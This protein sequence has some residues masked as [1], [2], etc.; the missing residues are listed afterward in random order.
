MD[1]V[2]H[3]ACM[4][5]CLAGGGYAV[6]LLID[7]YR[8][9]RKWRGRANRMGE[10]HGHSTQLDWFLQLAAAATFLVVAATLMAQ[11]AR[12][13][14]G[15]PIRHPVSN[16]GTVCSEYIPSEQISTPGRVKCDHHRP[17]QPIVGADFSNLPISDADIRRFLQDAP[18]I[19]W[20]NLISTNV[21]DACL[22][23][24][25][26]ATALTDLNVAHTAIT[27]AGLQ[28][29]AQ[30]DSLEILWLLGTQVT[31]KGLVSLQRLPRLRELGLGQTRISDAG[32]ETLQQ[33]PALQKVVVPEATVTARGIAQ[34]VEEVPGLKCSCD[35]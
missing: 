4:F 22:I 15:I 8:Q 33:F 7:C 3:Y 18:E 20:L 1:T 14:W 30:S 26:Q 31:D 6:W 5:L 24:L 35:L 2:G 27:D 34:L 10:I 12:H 29:L 28:H 23:D 9:R 13:C 17:G 16:Q 32:L 19:Q 21:T 11:S 25:K